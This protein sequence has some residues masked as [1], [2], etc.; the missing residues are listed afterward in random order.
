MNRLLRASSL[1]LL[2]L[3]LSVVSCN[4]YIGSIVAGELQLLSSV[5]PIEEAVNDPNLDQEQRDK[6]AFVIQA[7]DYAEQTVGLNV[8]T[9][10]QTFANLG[11]RS[12]AWNLSASRKDA[13]DPYYWNLPLVGRLPYI[14]YFNLDQARAERDR[15]VGEGYDTL[16]YEVDAFSTIGRL[17]D[18]VTSALL[19]RDLYSLADTVI[20]E[21]THNT[22]FSFG[23]TTFDESLATFVGRTAGQE[24]L[25]AT[26]GPDSAQVQDARHGYADEDRFQDF[27]GQMMDDLR[28]IYDGD[29]SF[30]D[31]LA[32]RQAVITAA[33]QRFGADVLP[34]LNDQAGFRLYT[35]FPFNNAFLLV[36]VRYYTDQDVFTA[37]YESTG[38][39]WAAT[40]HTFQEAAATPDPVA[41]LRG[42]LPS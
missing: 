29:A 34:L 40:I 20:H 12:L 13:F 31:K 3:S 39:D 18:P 35:V 41:Y 5:Q 28:P 33:Q 27:L 32:Q 16:I 21:L 2:L 30:E 37:I 36:N 15:L 25:A 7:R 38:R 9:S 1:V 22:V 17:P 8:G 19:Q 26:F 11:D 6:L 23:N 42:L 10:Y 14:G 4:T 24:F